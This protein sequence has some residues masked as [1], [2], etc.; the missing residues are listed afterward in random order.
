MQKTMPLRESFAFV[1][2]E[3]WFVEHKEPYPR[4]PVC[5]FARRSRHGGVCVC[6][7]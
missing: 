6:W 2:E 7:P 1:L 4:A 3:G 5:G